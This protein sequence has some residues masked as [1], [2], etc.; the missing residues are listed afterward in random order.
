MPMNKTH[1]LTQPLAGVCERIEDSPKTSLGILVAAAVIVALGIWVLPD[2]K[3]T[4]RMH[5]M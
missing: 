3:R 1:R 4:I 2:L 5:R